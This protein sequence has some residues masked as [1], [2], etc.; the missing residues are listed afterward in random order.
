MIYDRYGNRIDHPADGT[1]LRSIY[2]QA[3]EY[4]RSVGLS[5]PPKGELKTL[6]SYWDSIDD[7]IENP[8][9]KLQTEGVDFY[10]K[11]AMDPEVLGCRET[12]L[13]GVNSLD[14]E[15][16]PRAKSTKE[17]IALC[18]E[19]LDIAV[20][21]NFFEMV[22]DGAMYGINYINPVWEDAYP[23]G[24]KEYWVTTEFSV[25]PHEDFR[26]G[27]SDDPDDRRLVLRRLT[28]ADSE[29]GEDIP[30]FTLLTPT[31]RATQKN[32]YGV[33]LY[34]PAYKLVYI[35]TKILQYWAI[36]TE[37]FGLPKLL[38]K[39]D[40]AGLT[41]L[42]RQFKN[43]T[44]L[45]I[46]TAINTQIAKMRQNATVTLPPGVDTSTMEVGSK[47]N[48]VFKQFSERIDEWISV[49]FLGHT[50]TSKST[51]GKLGSENAA[52]AVLDKRIEHFG[53]YV[54]K[55]M[56]VLFRWH[57]Q[58]NFGH[59]HAPKLD[60]YDRE[61]RRKV[62]LQNSK[63]QAERD[64]ILYNFGVRFTD[65][66][67]E[68]EYAIPKKF[69]ALTGDSDDAVSSPQG[70]DNDDVEPED[71]EDFEDKAGQKL[72]RH[73][74]S[75]EAGKRKKFNLSVDP[76]YSSLVEFSRLDEIMNLDESELSGY[77]KPIYKLT[78]F[79]NDPKKND[80]IFSQAVEPIINYVKKAKSLEEILD[81]YADLFDE[82]DMSAFDL[83]LV[84][85]QFASYCKSWIDSIDEESDD[86]D[87]NDQDLVAKIKA[88]KFARPLM[89]GPKLIDLDMMFEIVEMT[90]EAAVDFLDSKG[91]ELNFDWRKAADVIKGHTFT[92]TG[93][94]KLQILNDVKD[95]VNVA[96]AEGQDMRTFR[97]SIRD[98]LA[99]KGW[100]GKKD[101]N[102]LQNPWR[103]NLIYHN[104]VFES[105]NSA[106]WDQKQSTI[107]VIPYIWSKAR[108]NGTH[109]NTTKQC[110]KLHNKVF[111]KD[112]KTYARYHRVMRH[113]KC[114]STEQSMTEARRKRMGLPVS[115]ASNFKDY[116]NAE[117]FE[118]T[119][120]W[121]PDVSSYP[122][123][124]QEKWE[125]YNE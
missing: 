8:D 111:R 20:E 113:H 103:T 9:Q 42:R 59:S 54:E 118:K 108:L 39:L 86:I 32:P 110:K 84:G 69:F 5:A 106:R 67:I 82:M 70:D 25:L 74:F 81:E 75:K 73:F 15:I 63:L 101:K 17:E 90:P 93:I 97:N 94:T 122:A 57:I 95:L 13:A 62:E 89:E 19:V 112:D 45:E 44:D 61:K 49:L 43:M 117:G 99:N 119:G 46:V 115:K 51:S 68:S 48:D 102:V 58:V 1:A 33:G 98:N 12:L 104:N 71:Q 87:K 76:I 88:S 55:F 35:K 38:T 85:G 36:F 53:D 52:E 30:D 34:K 16:I 29:R 41:S 18:E 80:G 7:I 2:A 14:R 107:D 26:F 100:L 124:L 66:Y 40:D 24:D 125:D 64:A 56:N 11:T 22:L 60:L 120:P 72:N 37:D 47:S 123:E 78:E 27:K 65:S 109:K 121:K 50:G 105:H 83:R 10:S 21:K 92:V 4:K 28:E 77:Q 116:R 79:L 96:I 114:F 31:Y 6:L 3:A 23:V 91:I